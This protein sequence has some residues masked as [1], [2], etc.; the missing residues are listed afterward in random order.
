M[1]PVLKWVN[2][3]SGMPAK[4]KFLFYLC[5][6]AWDWEDDHRVSSVRGMLVS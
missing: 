4:I 1:Q 3:D 2:C 5:R 6:S